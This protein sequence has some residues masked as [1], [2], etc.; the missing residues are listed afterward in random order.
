MIERPR[1]KRILT[2]INGKSVRENLKQLSKFGN[3]CQENWP[4]SGQQCPKFGRTFADVGQMLAKCWRMW[5]SFNFLEK[6]WSHFAKIELVAVRKSCAN[7]LAQTCCKMS[8]YS[9]KLASMQPRT[10]PS[11]LYSYIFSSYIFSF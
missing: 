11:K 4:R 3:I 5:T 7:L 2:S 8:M 1:K 10:W 9:K 6:R